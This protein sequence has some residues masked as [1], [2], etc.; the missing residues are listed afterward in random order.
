MRWHPATGTG[1]IALANS[2]YA[3]MAPLT[4]RV[5]ATLLRDGTSTSSRAAA[6]PLAPGREP[7]P[8]TIAAREAVNQLLVSWDDQ[9]ADRLFS[10]NV[11]LDTPYRERRDA[12]ALVRDRI[13]DFRQAAKAPEHDTPA[14]CRWWLAGE[15]G[16][17]QVQ[18]QLTPERSPRVQSLALAVPPAPGSPLSD[19]TSAF[20]AWLNGGDAV[21]T[22][23]GRDPESLG[24]R[25]RAASAWL[26]KCRPDVYTAGDG[27]KT[28]T[29]SLV[30]QHAR[31][32]LSL[33]LNP[34]TSQLVA[35]DLTSRMGE[36]S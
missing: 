23:D 21:P 9:A 2:T 10:P 32:T 15:R 4:Q 35:V 3:R 19:V 17:V 1:V 31:M 29:L 25:V 26:G 11:A 24:R 33:T 12:I 6:V 16:V 30:G 20:V 36:P 27:E 18:I 13:G 28:I 14:H 22:H 5:L 8:E 7:W 34:A